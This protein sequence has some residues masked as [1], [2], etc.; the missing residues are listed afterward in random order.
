[1][2]G[3]IR[4]KTNMMPLALVLAAISGVFFAE[5]GIKIATPAIA[6]NILDVAKGSTNQAPNGI[7]FDNLVRIDKRSYNVNVEDYVDLNPIS[8]ATVKKISA[9][10]VFTVDIATTSTGTYSTDA[11]RSKHVLYPGIDVK[12]VKPADFVDGAIIILGKLQGRDL[13]KF[14]QGLDDFAASDAQGCEAHG[15]YIGCK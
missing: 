10:R 2:F 1:M 15:S 6:A 7:D 5:S 14:I 13:L 8:S 11:M 9:G 12:E 4:N 3:A